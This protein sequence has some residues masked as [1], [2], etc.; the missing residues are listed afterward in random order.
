M[1][2]KLLPVNFFF[3]GGGDKFPPYPLRE[4]SPWST[5]GRISLP[6]DKF[7]VSAHTLLC[8]HIVGEFQKGVGAQFQ[9]EETSE[10]KTF[11]SCLIFSLFK[12]SFRANG[13]G[14][15]CLYFHHKLLDAMRK[16]NLRNSLYSETIFLFHRLN[17]YRDLV[18]LWSRNITVLALESAT[19]TSKSLG[20]HKGKALCISHLCNWW[21]S[22]GSWGCFKHT[23]YL[24]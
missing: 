8:L 7:G 23:L 1:M 12:L 4:T 19:F 18:A 5:V 17:L 10:W 16:R 20:T 13:W 9:C 14:E 3:W 22:P 24:Q 11:C 6:L 2:K 21:G 15:N